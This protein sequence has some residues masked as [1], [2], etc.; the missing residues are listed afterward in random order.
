MDKCCKRPD[1][2]IKINL[3]YAYYI[4]YKLVPPFQNL[5][6]ENIFLYTFIREMICFYGNIVLQQDLFL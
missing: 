3:G 4:H 6:K 5:V 1:F 2:A